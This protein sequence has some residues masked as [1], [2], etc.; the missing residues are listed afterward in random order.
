[1]LL[2]K[3][4]F[5]KLMKTTT[6]L[7]RQVSRQNVLEAISQIN[8]GAIS[9]FSDSIKFD[10]LFQG[11]RYPPKEVAGLALENFTNKEF[12]PSDFSGGE[13][14]SSFRA[15]QRCGFTIVPKKSITSENLTSVVNEILDL[16]RIYSST[17]T[18][19]MQRRGVLIR[20]ALPEIIQDK[21]ETLEPIFSSANFQLAI[22]GS[23]GKGRK[24]ESPWVRIYD[25]LMSPSATLGWYVV[26]HFSRDG[27]K[28]FL[29]LGCGAT[30]FRE[31]S[32]IKVPTIDLANQ[33]AW[34]RKTLN[35][36]NLDI[37]NFLDEMNLGGNSLSGH[38]EKACALVKGYQRSEFIESEFWKDLELFCSHLT[39]IYEKER[40]GKSPGID[41]PDLIAARDLIDEIARPK[42]RAS[43]GQG[44]GLSH[45][46]RQAIELRAMAVTEA[47]LTKLGFTEI[48]DKSRSESYDFSAMRD[49]VEWLIEVKGTTSVEGNSFLL[50][51][52]ELKLHK[53]NLGKTILAIVSN[54]DLNRTNADPVATG[55]KIDTFIPWDIL[56]WNFDPISYQAVKF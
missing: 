36:E 7:F 50:T 17:N 54:I 52:A 16:Q 32:L 40:I 22:E 21:F 18:P 14:S 2:E 26:L 49:G 25:P 37:S 12:K 51:A 29:A 9:K 4:E 41:P 42:K 33:V 39:V 44:R 1:M 56:K 11:K 38:F 30:I 43:K 28:S 13:S 20:D 24:N 10:V 55:G 23:D 45:L 27:T 34:A 8:N 31:G 5:E 15:L 19:E 53:A 46:E 35:D 6:E 47:E 48:T 3:L